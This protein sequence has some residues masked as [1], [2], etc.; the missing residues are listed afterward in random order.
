MPEAPAVSS[1]RGRRP[2]RG[3]PDRKRRGGKQRTGKSKQAAP[4]TPEQQAAVDRAMLWKDLRRVLVIGGVLLLIAVAL[5]MESVREQLF[6]IESIRQRLHPRGELGPRLMSYGIFAA[7]FAFLIAVGMPRVWVAIVAGSLY[8]ALLGSAIGFV[9]TLIGASGTYILGK[10]LFR[11]VMRRRMGR[12]LSIWNQRFRENALRW[13][14]YARLFP[15]SNATLTSLIC[16]ACKIR[17]RDYF[18]ANMVGFLPSTVVYA[19]LGSGAAKQNYWQFGVGI[20]AFMLAIA[21]QFWWVR[22][23]RS[24]LKAPKLEEEERL[25]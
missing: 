8:G 16:G 19:M 6:D 2:G 18:L 20:G 25:L 24:R 9:T 3:K 10:S 12:R 23:E 7:G 5:S 22:R 17:F 21:F 4:L 11:S 15:I 13:T 14:I 1:G